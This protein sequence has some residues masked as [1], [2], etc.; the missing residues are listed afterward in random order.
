MFVGEKLGYSAITLYNFLIMLAMIIIFAVIVITQIW[1]KEDRNFDSLSVKVFAQLPN[2]ITSGVKAVKHP[3]LWRILL[4][5][6]LTVP[7]ASGIEK[8]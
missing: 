1:I 3:V 8:F 6:F 4:A 7:V 2:Q 5:L